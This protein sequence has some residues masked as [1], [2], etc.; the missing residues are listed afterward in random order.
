MEQDIVS[1]LRGLDDRVPRYTSY[2]TA[3]RFR[4]DIGESEYLRAVCDS[5]GLPLPPPLSLYVHV[6]FCHS[7]CYYCGCN[8]LITRD[9]HK[10]TDYLDRLGSELSWHGAL[11]DPDREVDQLHL[12]GGTPTFLGDLQLQKLLTMIGSNFPLSRDAERE[13]SIEIDP[14]TVDAA[15]AANLV[16]MGFNR[17]SL[18]VQDFDQRV[19]QAVNRLQSYE[20]IAELV[21]AL[22]ARGKVAISFDLI[23]G[24]PHQNRISFAD[25]IE[26]TIMLRPD[27]IALYRYAHLPARFK[28]QKLLEQG[29]P[30]LDE[31]LAMFVAA[32]QRLVETGYVAIGLDHFALPEDELAVAWNNGT[33]QRNFQGYSTRGGRDLIGIG[34]SAIGHVGNCYVQNAPRFHD[35]RARA[36][37]GRTFVRGY[38]LNADDQMRERIIQDIMCRGAVDLQ[39]I[40]RRYDLSWPASFA[41]E[42]RELKDLEARGLLEMTGSRVVATPTGILA[43]RQIAK[44]FDRHLRESGVSAVYSKAV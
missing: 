3:D 20:Q 42:V 36:P 19:Q 40:A 28:A 41:A 25:T 35:W 31:R 26:R 44:V 39:A 13:F 14:R 22:R 24:L 11:F 23:Y 10:A 1:L 21:E 18:G 29:R 27:R 43:L 17:F 33:L 30:E 16:G 15:R 37:E 9:L 7:L 32:R 4:P 2:P 6:P 8:K 5:N 12:G 34:P 38:V